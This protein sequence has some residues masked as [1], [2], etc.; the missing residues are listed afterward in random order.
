MSSDPGRAE[1]RDPRLALLAWAK[2]IRAAEPKVRIW[3][4]PIYLAPQKVL[5]RVVF[6]ERHSLPQPPHVV[7]GTK[8]FEQF[9]W[10]NSDKVA[11]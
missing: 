6:S 2:A 5:R 4:D 11:G 8:R 1:R 10:P 7:A 9:F 3:E